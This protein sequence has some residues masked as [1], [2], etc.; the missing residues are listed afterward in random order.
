[1]HARGLAV[2][3]LAKPSGNAADEHAEDQG[4]ENDDEERHVNRVG[5]IGERVER[6]ADI[7]PVADREGDR[8]KRRAARE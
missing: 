3:A 4:R 2:A 6:E 7:P 5:R 1:M 8:Q